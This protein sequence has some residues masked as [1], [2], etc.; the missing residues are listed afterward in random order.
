MNI[1]YL[2]WRIALLIEN[3]QFVWIIWYIWKG[4]N[5]KVYY[6][7]NKDHRDTLRLVET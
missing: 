2:F 5:D 7:I 4:C 1:D 6:G 3:A